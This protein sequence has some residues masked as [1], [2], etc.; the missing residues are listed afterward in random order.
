[1]TSTRDGSPDLAIGSLGDGDGKVFVYYGRATWPATLTEADA[2]VTI[3]PDATADPKFNGSAFGL[4][5][6]RLGRLQR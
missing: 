6:A 5:I 2:D 3:V 1:M 4:A